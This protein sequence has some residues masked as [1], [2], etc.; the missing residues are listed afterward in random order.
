M[1][2]REDRGLC[3]FLKPPVI[4]Q[5]AHLAAQSPE[6][7]LMR[8]HRLFSQPKPSDPQA[9]ASLEASGSCEQMDLPRDWRRW[10]T[11]PL[12]LI[13]LEPGSKWT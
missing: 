11:A 9:Q 10:T 13:R 5:G 8:P 12:A 1:P 4:P 7:C 6:G 3:E 2:F